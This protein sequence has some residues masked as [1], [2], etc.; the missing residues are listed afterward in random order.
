[1]AVAQNRGT[2]PVQTTFSAVRLH[3][4]QPEAQ[5]DSAMPN[6]MKP[7]IQPNLSVDRDP[8]VSP[9]ANSD[10]PWGLQSPGVAI[11]KSR[12]SNVYTLH[13][14]VNEV[15]LNCTVLTKKDRLVKGLRS[16]D[17]RVWEDGIPQK[18]SSF[19]YGDVPI[20]LGILIDD[21]ASMRDKVDAVDRAALTL[22]K[23]SNPSDE[24]FIVH[25]DENAYLDQGFTT[26]VA[27]L[28]SA[29]SHYQSKGTTA[30][31]DAVYASANELQSR[32][33]WPKQVLLII[34]DGEDDASRLTLEQAAHRVERM[35]GPVVYS[36]GLLF[37]SESQREA[38]KAKAALEELSNETGGVA[39]FP[40]S[41]QDVHE[42]ALAIAQDIRH[43]YTIG[44]HST[45]PPSLGGFRAVRVDARAPG[46]GKL[47]VRTR[48][49]YYPRQIHQ[50][51][52]VQTAK[53]NVA[54][55]Q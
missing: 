46:L 12:K 34:T 14:N 15:I 20:S 1:M 9:D 10:L 6:Y 49:G 8:I 24:T 52:A 40:G 54:R 37:D 35:G 33:K 55:S 19:Q 4:R 16:Q 26:N 29:L 11:S 51:H 22:V 36:I 13:E 30:L 32:A 44:Y 50:M 41:L 21:S 39:F 25:F 47:I 18:I 3:H 17:F 53:A 31:Y 5:Q 23:A 27:M 43:Q 38:R 48:K 42:V 45:I 28:E 7:E 2:G